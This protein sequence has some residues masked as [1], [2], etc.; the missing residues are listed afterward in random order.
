[1]KK[2]GVLLVAVVMVFGLAQIANAATVYTN[3]DWAGSV[4]LPGGDNNANVNSI[5]QMEISETYFHFDLS[6]L[7]NSLIG[8]QM[9]FNASMWFSMDGERTVW[10][11]KTS[12]GTLLGEKYFDINSY[13][14]YEAINIGTWDGSDELTL[15]LTGPSIGSHKCALVQ[16]IESGNSAYLNVNNVVPLPPTVLLFGS[17]LL[18]LAGWR[19]FRKG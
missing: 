7:D 3:Y 6:S 12:L 5:C 18:G 4:F 10:K 17:S 2:Y 8:S 1:M 11:G 14:T 16:M 9:T 15:T 13:F 19:R